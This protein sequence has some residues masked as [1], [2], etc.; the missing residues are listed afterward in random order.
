MPEPPIFIT[1]DRQDLPALVQALTALR[2]KL[3]ESEDRSAM[4]VGKLE[5]NLTACREALRTCRVA[6]TPHVSVDEDAR[7]ARDVAD[8]TLPPAGGTEC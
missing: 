8:A 1:H 2:N 4:R 3:V 7:K 5:E 6:L